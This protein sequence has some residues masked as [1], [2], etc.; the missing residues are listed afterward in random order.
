M[1][2][3]TSDYNDKT[4]ELIDSFIVEKFR[5]FGFNNLTDIQKIASPKILQKYI[6]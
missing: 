6:H 2:M 1:V 5:T 3:P 4:I